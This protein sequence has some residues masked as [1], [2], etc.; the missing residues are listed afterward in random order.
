[1]VGKKCVGTELVASGAL[2]RSF[3]FK[4]KPAAIGKLTKLTFT[5]NGIVVGRKS[6]KA[7]LKVKAG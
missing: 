2:V 5:A 1:V 7:S 4:L 3:Q 6:V